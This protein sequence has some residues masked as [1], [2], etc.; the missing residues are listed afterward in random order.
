MEYD[1]DQHMKDQHDDGIYIDLHHDVKYVMTRY[2][3][4]RY[5][6]M[7]QVTWK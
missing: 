2:V 5:D 3:K 6:N 4:P 7:V 1:T